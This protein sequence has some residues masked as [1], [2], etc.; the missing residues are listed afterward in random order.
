MKP[1]TTSAD[2]KLAIQQLEQQQTN[3][4]QLLKE[5]YNKTYESFKPINIIKS[6]FKELVAAPDLKTDVINAAVGLAA[7]IVTK[8]LM[9]GK[10]INPFKKLLGIIVEMAVAKTV[11]KNTDEI[12]AAGTAV[13][14]TLFSKKEGRVTP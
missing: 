9:I 1:I 8:K 7:G 5:E 3:D 14:N 4:L 12:K 10:T 2:L 13:F 11:A 6:S